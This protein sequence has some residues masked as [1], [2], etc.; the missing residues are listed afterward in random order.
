M[1]DK[2]TFL[3]SDLANELGVPRT[4]INDWLKRFER[5]LTTEMA[6]KR[7]VYTLESFEVLKAV[8]QLRNAG[9]SASQ[10]E[11]E[12]AGKFAIRADEVSVSEVE[13][14]EE[15]TSVP[16]AAPAEQ[17]A[18]AVEEEPA[19]LPAIRRE[20]FERFIGTMES[21]ANA[22]KSRRRSSLYVWCF[23]IL[24]ALFAIVTAWYL[25]QLVN[26][27]KSNTLRLNKIMVE[28]AAERDAARK[29]E[30]LANSVMKEQ[31]KEI[32]D[33][34]SDLEKS[35]KREEEAKRRI[36]DAAKSILKGINDAN[37][38]QK[39][40]TAELKS[41]FDNELNKL[42]A[43]MQKL[44]AAREQLKASQDQLVKK[45]LELEKMKQES[46]ELRR[47]LEELEKQKTAPAKEAGAVLSAPVQSAAGT[48][49]GAGA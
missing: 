47:K 39:K 48:G 10:I 26:L 30:D 7:R 28:N 19:A 25:A 43:D 38:R 32:S 21:I 3:V 5:Y 9:K 41:A 22:E 17:K 6:G 2:K 13:K 42:K 15:K 49:A 16:T 37:M 18:A 29:R 27:Q 34:R 1:T 14:S 46:A 35:R 4:T 8:N 44:E 12:L 36:D 33:L 23:V 40:Q 24:L 31:K 45:N 11:A 20:E